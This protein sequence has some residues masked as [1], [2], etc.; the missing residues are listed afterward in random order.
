M[1]LDKLYIICVEQKELLKKVY[2]NIMDSI[3]L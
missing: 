3:N 1:K 2:D